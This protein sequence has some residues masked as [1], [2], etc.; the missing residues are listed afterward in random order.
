M[1]LVY[2]IRKVYLWRKDKNK[3]NDVIV[4]T[5]H[6]FEEHLQV[7]DKNTVESDEKYNNRAILLD[8]ETTGLTGEDELIELSLLLVEFDDNGNLEPI[9]E[10]TGLREPNCRIHPGAQ[11]KH[12][13]TMDDLAGEALDLESC[14]NIFDKSNFLVAHNSSFDKKYIEDEFDYLSDKIWLCSYRYIDWKSR[15]FKS[16][17]LVDLAKSHDIDIE[18]EHRAESDTLALF[19][20]L[21]QK[22]S[23]RTTYFNQLLRNNNI[24]Q[25][26]IDFRDNQK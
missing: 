16:Q 22:A 7:T 19:E 13:L 5:N 8:T 23:P 10:Y 2:F 9:A 21:N 18:D 4:K 11:A 15:G 26:D 3:R 25:R 17:K 14:Y 6:S 12:G 24:R 20:L 1:L